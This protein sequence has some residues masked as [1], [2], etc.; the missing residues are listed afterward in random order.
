MTLIHP[1]AIIEDGAEL[2]VDVEIGPYSIVKKDVKLGDRVKLHSQVLVDGNTTIGEESEIYPFSA[3]GTAPQDLS[4]KGE[5]VRLIIGKNNIIR[6]NVLINPGTMKDNGETIIGDN[7]LFMG[8]THVAHDAILGNDIVMVNQSMVAGHVIV[9]DGV[10]IGGS[11]P[12]HQYVKLGEYCMIGGAGAVAQDIPPYCLAE[13]NRADVRSLNLVGIRRKVEKDDVAALV[14]A[15]KSIFRSGKN[16]KD[17]ASELINET[18][19]EKV[20]KLCDFI[21]ATK[22]GIPY[23]RK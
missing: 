1:T 7:N 19:N 23:E 16:L 10:I 4:Y 22:R 3:V 15:Y 21:I 6:E 14:S 12:I 20:K 13:G 8:S 11:T 5:D 17:V 18:E 2:G 9:G